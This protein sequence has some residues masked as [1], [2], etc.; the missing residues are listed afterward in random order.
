MCSVFCCTSRDVDYKAMTEGFYRT[1]S[2]GPDMSRIERTPTGYIAFHRLAIMGLNAA[3]MQPFSMGKD[4]LVCNGEIYG[5]RPVKKRLEELGYVF[6]SDSDCEILLP[7]YHEYGLKMFS[8]LDAEFALILYDGEKGEYIAARDPIGIRPLYYAYLKNGAIVFAS[9]PKNL[10]GW[11][12]GDIMPFPP[13]HYYYKGK[14]HKFCDIADVEEVC[15]DSLD[16]ICRNIREKLTEGV[17]KRLRRGRA[18][19][20]FAVGRA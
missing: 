2:R 7:M 17:R 9:E 18:R 8:M 5:F 1:V 4:K 20:V 15:R 14:F 6:L 3:G 12:Q 11:T 19:G 13:G 10:V 16:A